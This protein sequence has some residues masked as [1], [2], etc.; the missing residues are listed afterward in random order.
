MHC[1]S[2]PECN[3]KVLITGTCKRGALG[4]RVDCKMENKVVGLEF[5][6]LKTQQHSLLS[7]DT[8]VELQLLTYETESVCIAEAN[9]WVTKELI[10]QEYADVFTGLGCFPGEYR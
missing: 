8:C 5:E 7:L 10:L 3:I 6:L 1:A 4:I 9:H 2:S